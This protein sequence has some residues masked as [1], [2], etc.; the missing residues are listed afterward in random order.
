MQN[1]GCGLTGL[2]DSPVFAL[3][4]WSAHQASGP[5]EATKRRWNDDEVFDHST[6][7]LD[8][9]LKLKN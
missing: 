6:K 5:T 9:N 8:Q 1:F 7:N 4:S 3:Y 2:V